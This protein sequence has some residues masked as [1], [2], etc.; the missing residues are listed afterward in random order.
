MS[1]HRPGRF[2]RNAQSKVPM[3][4][5]LREDVAKI[6]PEYLNAPY[7]EEMHAGYDKRLDVL[8]DNVMLLGNLWEWAER[9]RKKGIT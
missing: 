3:L 9:A 7:T 4:K 5:K 8:R 1:F 2:S 6:D